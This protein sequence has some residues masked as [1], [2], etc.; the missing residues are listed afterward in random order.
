M[1]QCSPTIILCRPLVESASAK[2]VNKRSPLQNE[3]SLSTLQMWHNWSKTMD[4]LQT[5]CGGGGGIRINFVLG[6]FHQP[7]SN[8]HKKV[9]SAVAENAC[10]SESILYVL[11]WILFP[12]ALMMS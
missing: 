8:L 5:N 6:M 9:T 7:K 1:G 10:V 11:R 2:H 12:P 4:I 3:L